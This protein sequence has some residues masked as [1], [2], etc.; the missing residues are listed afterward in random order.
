VRKQENRVDMVRHDRVKIDSHSPRARWQRLEFLFHSRFET[1]GEQRNAI[2]SADGNEI[3]TRRRVIEILQAHPFATHPV[4]GSKEFARMISR[5]WPALHM[6]LPQ[7]L[8]FRTVF[9]VAGSATGE[10]R[11]SS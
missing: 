7:R 5:C 1:T 10:G 6:I 4:S 9:V 3:C 2:Q 11:A 8:Q